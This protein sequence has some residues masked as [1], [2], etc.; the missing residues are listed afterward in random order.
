MFSSQSLAL[1]LSIQLKMESKKKAPYFFSFSFGSI[2]EQIRIYFKAT[3][4]VS[5]QGVSANVNG[6]LFQGYINT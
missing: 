3:K 5:C 1:R 4:K 2:I 6:V